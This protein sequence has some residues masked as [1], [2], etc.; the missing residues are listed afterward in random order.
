M[1]GE[2]MQLL[3]ITTVPAQIEFNIQKAQLQCRVQP[4]GFTLNKTGGSLEV[5]TQGTQMQM[6]SD[7]YRA[8][9]DRGPV[10]DTMKKVAQQSAQK[11]A[12][13]VGR[14]VDLGNQMMQIQ[15]GANIPD[16]LFSRMLQDQGSSLVFVPLSPVEISWSQ[17]QMSMEYTPVKQNFEWQ[18]AKNIMEYIP[19]K[20]SIDIKQ[21]PEVHFEYLG[22]PNYIPRRP[23]QGA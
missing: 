16:L 12:E 4:L 17:P 6:N 15:K 11:G 8:D 7:A 23:A 9:M 3:R 13:A 18:T 19:G 22:G 2:H 20:F 21:H 14:H 5:N 10:G 1:R